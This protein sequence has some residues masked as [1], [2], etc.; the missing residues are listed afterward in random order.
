V[1]AIGIEDVSER[2]HFTIGDC[3]LLNADSKTRF[4]DPQSEIR[5][6]KSHFTIGD[7]GL[8]N[9][10]SKTRFFDPQSE[11]RSPKSEVPR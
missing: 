7:C 3:G 5:S 9:A 4:F 6:P 2:F 11:I 1:Y 8:L 10:D